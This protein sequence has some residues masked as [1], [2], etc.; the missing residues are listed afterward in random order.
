MIQVKQANNTNYN[1]DDFSIELKNY[2]EQIASTQNLREQLVNQIY[3]ITD[4]QKAINDNSIQSKLNIFLERYNDSIS[5]I[6]GAILS[7]DDKLDYFNISYEQSSYEKQSF[8]MKL[9]SKC[10]EIEVI[11][12]QVALLNSQAIQGAKKYVTSHNKGDIDYSAN[13]NVNNAILANNA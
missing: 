1:T 2:M 13:I 10:K 3:I 5:H 4:I 12:D 9:T 6:N 7:K 11:F 8:T